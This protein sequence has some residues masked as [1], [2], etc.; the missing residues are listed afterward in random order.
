MSGK[1]AGTNAS[2]VFVETAVE[3]AQMLLLFIYYEI[4]HK[5]H[6]KNKRKK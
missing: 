2:S 6:N 3:M 4:V 5:V 1:I